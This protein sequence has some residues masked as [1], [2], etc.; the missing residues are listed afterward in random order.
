MKYSFSE[1]K[2]GEDLKQVGFV[3]DN[4]E[5]RL[6]VAPT[7]DDLP[8]VH[9]AWRSAL[10]LGQICQCYDDVFKIHEDLEIIDHYDEIEEDD[11]VR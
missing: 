2:L 7:E 6:I 1:V 5:A 11:E 3:V 9:R 10:A 8:Y 4:P